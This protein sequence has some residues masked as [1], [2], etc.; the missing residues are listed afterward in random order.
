M[1]KK[2][3]RA[4][5]DAKKEKYCLERSA[6]KSQRQAYLAAFPVSAR[7]K[8]ATVDT[9]ASKLEKTDEVQTRL[10]E[11]REQS[12]KQAGLSRKKLLDRLEEIIG[13]EDVTFRG[14]DVLKAIELYIEL[15]GYREES[16]ESEAFKRAHEELIRAIRGTA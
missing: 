5:L 15:C 9:K 6:G 2:G 10:R 16:G 13:T 1:T 14:S 8:R 12:A 7:W 3:V 11:L 4:L